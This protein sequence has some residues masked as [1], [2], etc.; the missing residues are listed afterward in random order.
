MDE[1]CYAREICELILDMLSFLEW[2]KAKAGT[3]L[4]LNGDLKGL[5]KI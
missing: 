3:L 5:N 2:L 1:R 4:A